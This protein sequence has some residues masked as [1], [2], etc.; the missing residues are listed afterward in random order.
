MAVLKGIRGPLT[1]HSF[2]L[3]P[4][5]TVLGR[6]SDADIVLAHDAVSRPHARIYRDSLGQWMIEDLE[7]LN[8]TSINGAY[9]RKGKVGARVLWHRDRIKMC[10]FQFIFESDEAPDPTATVHVTDENVQHS[11]TSLQLPSSSAEI[12]LEENPQTKLRAFMGLIDSLANSI[13]VAELIPKV[14]NSLVTVF[15]RAQRGFIQLREP[16]SERLNTAATYPPQL[17]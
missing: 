6:N 8:G 15:P 13:S 2:E 7:S 5:G 4:S 1:G 12:D 10:G 11:M 9:L 3:N 16:E 17:D 14:L